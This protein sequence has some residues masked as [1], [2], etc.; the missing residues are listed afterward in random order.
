MD[1]WPLQALGWIRTYWALNGRSKVYDTI[2]I[3]SELPRNIYERKKKQLRLRQLG[4]FIHMYTICMKPGSFW[5]RV[6]QYIT[7]NCYFSLLTNC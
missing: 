6:I 1:M 3:L 5:D 2:E 4:S 7:S